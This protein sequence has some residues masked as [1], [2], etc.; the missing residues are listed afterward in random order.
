MYV[1]KLILMQIV[2]ENNANRKFF[3]TYLTCMESVFHQY[4]V[5]GHFKQIN[6]QIF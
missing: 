4:F 3:N 5:A 1:A 2:Y 6:S